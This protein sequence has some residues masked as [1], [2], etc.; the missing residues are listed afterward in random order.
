MRQADRSVAAF[1]PKNRI[2]VKEPHR[3][4]VSPKHRGRSFAQ[5]KAQDDSLGGLEWKHDPPVA[6][7][8]CS[9]GKLRSVFLIMLLLFI[10][11]KHQM[12]GSRTH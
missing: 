4:L 6:E 10:G 1:W 5:K 2:L 8:S 3:L 7:S 12:G 9:Q 11:D